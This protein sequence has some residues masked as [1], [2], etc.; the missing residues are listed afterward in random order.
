MQKMKWGKRRGDR[1]WEIKQKK[2]RCE[3]EKRQFNTV[4]YVQTENVSSP[5]TN[6][7]MP[8][9]K[10][11]IIS[12]AW[13]INVSFLCALCTEKKLKNL[14]SEIIQNVAVN[15]HKNESTYKTNS[16]DRPVLLFWFVLV[17]WVTGPELIWPSPFK[18]LC[19]SSCLGAWWSSTDHVLQVTAPWPRPAGSQQRGAS[20]TSAWFGHSHRE[21]NK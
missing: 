1:E 10:L 7:E 11:P 19:A 2:K 20:Q 18:S 12:F 3:I 21:T 15:V 17:N 5:R 8:I 6:K 14:F 13:E 9:I 16:T 4:Q